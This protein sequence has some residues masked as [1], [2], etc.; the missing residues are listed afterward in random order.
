MSCI[1][2]AA[3]YLVA[4]NCEIIGTVN[5]V[6]MLATSHESVGAVDAEVTARIRLSDKI[7]TLDF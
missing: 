1:I 7:C 6:Y 3:I 4:V 5:S 2:I